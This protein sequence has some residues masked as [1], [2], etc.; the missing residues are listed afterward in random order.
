MSYPYRLDAGDFNFAVSLGVPTAVCQMDE[1]NVSLTTRGV[2][3]QCG[4]DHVYNLRTRNGAKSFFLECDDKNPALAMWPKSVP[5]MTPNGITH[6]TISYDELN[7]APREYWY[8]LFHDQDACVIQSPVGTAKTGL[9][10]ELVARI[11]HTHQIFG[12]PL[13]M[14]KDGTANPST[15]LIVEPGVALTGQLFDRCDDMV[16]KLRGVPIST[17]IVTKTGTRSLRQYIHSVIFHYSETNNRVYHNCVG[18]KVVVCCVNSAHKFLDKSDPPA[19]IIFDESEYLGSKLDQR[20]Q[21][22]KMYTYDG[23]QLADYVRPCIRS[24]TKTLF[25]SAD[26]GER[27]R[28][29]MDFLHVRGRI[30]WVINTPASLGLPYIIASE[31]EAYAAALCVLNTIN[32]EQLHPETVLEPTHLFL[33]C[34]CPERW[35]HIVNKATELGIGHR[36]STS[37]ESFAKEFKADEH[38]PPRVAVVSEHIFG[39]GFSYIPRSAKIVV[40][41]L[42]ES[43]CRHERREFDAVVQQAGR[44]RNNITR[45][46]AVESVLLPPNHETEAAPRIED[47][48]DATQEVINGTGVLLDGDELEKAAQVRITHAR[49]VHQHLALETPERLPA[50]VISKGLDVRSILDGICSDTHGQ[51]VSYKQIK[52]IENPHPPKRTSMQE[53][54]LDNIVAMLAKLRRRQRVSYARVVAAFDS[55]DP[56]YKCTFEE[57]CKPGVDCG[58]VFKCLVRY[59]KHGAAIDYRRVLLSRIHDDTFNPETSLYLTAK[60]IGEELLSELIISEFFPKTYNELYR[61]SGMD[62]AVASH[63]ASIGVAMSSS[64]TAFDYA[65]H[66]LDLVKDVLPPMG[67][68]AAEDDWDRIAVGYIT[69]SGEDSRHLKKSSD[70]AIERTATELGLEEASNTH[71][72]R[73]MSRVA[74]STLTYCLIKHLM[75]DALTHGTNILNDSCDAYDACM[76]ATFV[77]L[78]DFCRERDPKPPRDGYTD[79]AERANVI[80]RCF[81]GH[82]DPPLCFVSDMSERKLKLSFT[83]KIY[84]ILID[85]RVHEEERI[86][87]IRD[88]MLI[89]T[90]DD[91]FPALPMLTKS[92]QLM[93]ETNGKARIRQ[94]L[95]GFYDTPA[96]F[97]NAHIRDLEMAADFGDIQRGI[98]EASTE[99]LGDF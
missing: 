82:A 97:M 13:R 42:S 77:K 31:D 50:R 56:D 16:H 6:E 61:R 70:E 17:P 36:S 46:V 99:L 41:G 26:A 51:I 25:L 95:R 43:E 98:S 3:P 38:D 27:T 74:K 39:I 85:D 86:A 44:V 79:P 48:V 52:D 63:L 5:P 18:V 76:D 23:G 88:V 57:P 35:Q 45:I 34:H 8:S 75:P 84:P 72:K 15:I 10:A 12:V 32:Q 96:E 80:M 37:R 66:H 64:K 93:E 78:F 22:Q 14:N 4:E 54:R 7:K 24:G 9:I 55:T 29:F 90:R 83:C 2:C 68:V 33:V 11:G 20:I 30:R 62:R 81:W 40:I 53:N 89:P 60:Q 65:S 28:I 92:Q 59:A 21:H 1:N 58:S 47:D 19:L 91:S 71:M 94:E 67:N 69:R 73:K 87:M 49:R